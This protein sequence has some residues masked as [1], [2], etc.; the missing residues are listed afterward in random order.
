[1][2]LLKDPEF[3]KNVIKDLDLDGDDKSKNQQQD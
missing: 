1:M 2:N 3:L